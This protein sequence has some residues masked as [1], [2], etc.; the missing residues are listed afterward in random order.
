MPFASVLPFVLALATAD[1]APDERPVEQPVA[2]ADAPIDPIIAGVLDGMDP[3][4]RAALEGMDPAALDALVARGQRGDPLDATE[5]QILAALSQAAIL[6]FD[7][8][9]SYQTGDITIGD[10]LAVLHLSDH[11]RYLGPSDAARVL[12]EAWGNPPSDLT[13]G[14]IVPAEISPMDPKRGWG[15]V[16]T[17]SQEGHVK[18]DDAE[19]IDY[20]ELLTQLQEA[21]EANNPARTA[22]GYPALHLRGWAEPPRYVPE[23]RSLY[24]AQ[25][26]AADGAPEGS[27]NYAIRVLGRKGV[28]ELNAVG[29]MSQLPQIKPAMERV[30]AL[31]EF[32]QGNRYIDFDP[33]LD[34]VAA[35]GIGGL[36]AGK[37]ALKAGLFA[38]LLKLLIAGKKLIFVL[39]IGLVAGIK[40]LLGRNKKPAE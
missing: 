17:Y 20:D 35:Y 18:D 9:L 6:S 12:T 22:Q 28:L 23:I 14:M 32:K 16:I 4:A 8:K 40:G 30:Y 19:D 13:L 31:V 29:A 27:L 39:A 5:Q 10:E 1:I 7:A 25:E 11:F 38:G 3:G 37:V 26:L 33:D 2:E 21:T 34:E 24:W 36:I 15:V